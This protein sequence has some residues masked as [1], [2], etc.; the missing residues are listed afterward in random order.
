LT[1]EPT[2]VVNPEDGRKKIVRC[3]NL[4]HEQGLQELLA[5]AGKAKAQLLIT[6]PAED[7]A[8]MDNP[9]NGK[10]IEVEGKVKEI[11]QPEVQEETDIPEEII[12]LA[13]L[14]FKNAGEFKSACLKYFKLQPSQVDKET[15]MYDLT[16]AGQRKKA[17]LEILSVYR[18]EV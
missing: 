7:E 4:R 17:W 10:V 13:S 14:E 5:A 12:D 18:K 1:L 15:G 11:E 6:A 2:D 16:N 3:L 9:E 8:P